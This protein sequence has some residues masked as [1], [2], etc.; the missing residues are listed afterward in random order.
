MIREEGVYLIFVA[1]CMLGLN[2]NIKKKNHNRLSRIGKKVNSKKQ[3][4]I[5]SH[6]LLFSIPVRVPLRVV[7]F[8]CEAIHPPKNKKKTFYSVTGGIFF[9]AKD[10]WTCDEGK[11]GTLVH[12]Y[13]RGLPSIE[14]D[15]QQSPSHNTQSYPTYWYDVFTTLYECGELNMILISIP[16]FP[17]QFAIATVNP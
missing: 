9:L 11:G 1:I 7:H 15:T 13:R 12:R 8:H 17:Q 4:I 6:S 10:S 3:V 2:L 14:R 16:T 5:F